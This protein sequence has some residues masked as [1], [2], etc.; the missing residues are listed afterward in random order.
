MPYKKVCGVYI[1]ISWKTG[2]HYVGAARHCFLRWALHRSELRRKIHCYQKKFEKDFDDGDLTFFLLQEYK[3]NPTKRELW[4]L[5]QS[6]A[7]QFPDRVNKFKNVTGLGRKE[8]GRWS[9]MQRI[10]MSISRRGRKHSK[11]TRMKISR[12]LR[13]RKHS[14]EHRK[15]NSKARLG[16]KRGPMSPESR[17]KNRLS[18]LGL[19]KTP[20]HIANWKKSR[21]PGK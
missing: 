3:G 18:H 9:I 2:N 4:N 19:K 15:N 6:W 8:P 12:A 5:E 17:E 11:S 20:E 13:G 21:W 16:I 7:N 10:Q 14:I 1:M